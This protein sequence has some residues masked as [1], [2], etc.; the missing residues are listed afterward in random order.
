MLA[1]RCFAHLTAATHRRSTFSFDR[2]VR[3][4]R[5]ATRPGQVARHWFAVRL[6]PAATDTDGQPRRWTILDG[7]PA[8][9][10]VDTAVTPLNAHRRNLHLVTDALARAGVSYFVIPDSDG[11]RSRVGVPQR[12]RGAALRALAG[13][14]ALTASVPGGRPRPLP[15]RAGR[16]LRRAPVVQ[17]FQPVASPDGRL[18]YGGQ[19]AC[20]IEFWAVDG[21]QLRAPRGNGF[22]TAMPTGSAPVRLTEAEVTAF[23]PDDEIG[24]HLSRAP[25]TR[26]PADW[27]D[28]PVDL[29]CCWTDPGDP[30]WRTRQQRVMSRLPG[31]LPGARRADR[32]RRAA[33]G[34]LTSGSVGWDDSHGL[35]HLLRSVHLYAPWIRR[36]FLVTAYQLPGWLDLD[37][38]RLTVVDHRDLLGGH[39]VLPTFNPCVVESA[40]HEIDGLA[41]RFLYL[42]DNVFLGRPVSRTTFF[43]ANG[44]PRV[45]TGTATGPDATVRGIVADHFDRLVTTTVPAGV[46]L[47]LRRSTLAE[48]C[49]SAP[50]LVERIRGHQVQRG[51][52]VSLVRSLHHHWSFLRGTAVPG[53]WRHTVIDPAVRGAV[54]H[55]HHLLDQR[56]VDTFRLVGSADGALGADFLDHYF[57]TASPFEVSAEV[58]AAR[59]PFTATELAQRLLR[60]QV[61]RFPAGPQLRL[62]PAL[63]APGQAA[64]GL[65]AASVAP[66]QPT[67]RT[68]EQLPWTDRP[69][70]ADADPQPAADADRRLDAHVHA[71]ADA[72]VGRRCG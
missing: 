70:P 55:L 66:H 42:P 14:G 60:P 3:L 54:A 61:G 17:V 32:H 33:T 41:E 51:D 72:L 4:L 12:E 31:V 15:A 49:T 58:A 43:E 56:D 53:Q 40:L 36:I 18:A 63:P 68:A 45:P 67:S 25:F 10:V 50:D 57:P 22:T 59:A 37:D 65:P 35:R 26:R 30:R 62:T 23:A 13:T 38:P 19:A 64:P 47:P 39:A 16:Q 29:V 20:E 44:V 21:D 27:P 7:R 28:F 6:R 1:R 8:L 46:P 48:I 11:L 69:A 5:L 34:N 71:D 52:D 2:Q 9:A 24:R